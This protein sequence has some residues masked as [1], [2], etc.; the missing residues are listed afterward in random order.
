METGKYLCTPSPDSLVWKCE[1]GIPV[2]LWVELYQ[3]ME[4]VP[5]KWT[6]EH[7]RGPIE[8]LRPMLRTCLVV[9]AAIEYSRIIR[10]GIKGRERFLCL[11]LSPAFL[12]LSASQFV[13]SLMSQTPGGPLF[14][15]MQPLYR[16]IFSL[17][18]HYL[19]NNMT[20]F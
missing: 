10:V 4:T 9:F 8:S 19:L 15:R 14:W 12:R 7:Q 1:N 6:Y 5:S 3:R 16:S 17:K 18:K 20:L 11:F 2:P 13:V